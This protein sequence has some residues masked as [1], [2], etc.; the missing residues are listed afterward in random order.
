MRIDYNPNEKF[1]QADEG[2]YLSQA[3]YDSEA[4]RLLVRY[5]SIPATESTADWEEI[6]EADAERIR[7]AKQAAAGDVTQL[8]QQVT[9]MGQQVQQAAETA[10]AAQQTAEQAAQSSGQNASQTLLTTMLI[11]TYPL[12][13][14]QA[15]QVKDLYP[16]WEDLIGQQLAVGFKLQYGGQLYKVIQQHTAQEQ[17]KP[18]TD[19]ASLYALVSATATEHAGTQDDPIPY[20]PMMLIEKDKYYTQDGVLYI[21]LMDAPNGYPNDLKDLPT[22]AKAI[23]LNEE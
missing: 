21:G 11:N 7:A 5:V 13:D 2:K 17:W 3:K 23:Q 10:Q 22:L 9:Q 6:T 1:L 15:L 4:E 8:A 20:E 14:A 16:Q 18:G 19:T 12:T